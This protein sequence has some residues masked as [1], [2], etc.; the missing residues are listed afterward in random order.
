MIDFTRKMTCPKGPKR[1]QPFRN[2]VNVSFC[3]GPRTKSGDP[4]FVIYVITRFIRVIQYDVKAALDCRDKPG[5]DRWRVIPIE[6]PTSAHVGQDFIVPTPKSNRVIPEPK[7][8]SRAKTRDPLCR[9]IFSMDPGSSSGC[10]LKGRKT[11]SPASRPQG[12]NRGKAYP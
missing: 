9:P 2:P 3:I 12:S 7:M 11:L 10:P 1:R 5:N 6:Y 4:G 8:S